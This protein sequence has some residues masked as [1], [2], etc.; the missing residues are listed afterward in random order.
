MK[1][2][3]LKKTVSAFTAVLMTAA[4]CAG[5]AA[6][7]TDEIKVFCDG[8]RMEFDVPAQIINDRVM[9]PMRAVFESFGAKVKWDEETQ[10]ITAK[11]KSKT[12]V[13]TVGSCDMTKNDETYTFDAAP[14]IVDGRTL[15][16]VRAIGDM[17]SL[18][19]EWDETKK[20]VTISSPAD[21]DESYKNNTG[22]IDL[23]D[24][25]VTGNG[26]S[27]NGTVV[28]V[29]EGGDFE[30]VG[31]AE[32]GQITVDTKD[33]VKLRLSG[34]SL[35]NKSGSAIY[36]KDADKAYITL[37]DGTENY[38]S[39]ADEYTSGDSDEKACITSR[40]N[41]EIK[42]GGTLNVTGNYNNGI[43]SSDS[44][45]M[46]NGTI[47]ITA[48]N[49]GIHVNDTFSADGAQINVTAESDGI[50]SEE[51]VDITGGSVNVTTTGDVKAPESEQIGMFRGEER[52][53]RDMTANDAASQAETESGEEVTSKG[54]KADWM[55]DISGGSVTVNSTDHAVSCASDVNIK[56]GSLN[57]SSLNK[58][59]KS[60]GNLTVDDGNIVVTQASEGMESKN[61]MTINGGDIEIHANDDGLNAGGG[62]VMQGGFGF[63]RD[64]NGAPDVNG[65]PDMNGMPNMRGM[66][67]MNGTPDMNG[68]PDMNGTPPM[69]DGFGGH[70]TGEISTE[71]H[72]QINGGV[73]YIDAKNDGIDSNGSI[74]I[75]G[76]SVIVEGSPT[77]GG[78]ESGLDSDGATVINGGEVLSAG[79]SMTTVTGE[80]NTVLI[81]FE[82]TMPAG[83]EFEIKNADASTVFKTT[84]SEQ[85]AAMLYSSDK[86]ETG[87]EYKV[88]ADGEEKY[89]FTVSD[90]LTTVGTARRGM[91]AMH[92]ARRNQN[93]N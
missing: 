24:F 21:D 14:V 53:T 9:A 64:M 44:L 81:N 22:T 61:I 59:I 92:G 75:D 8:E 60:E 43:D 28:T 50:Q 26:V 25:S 90:T 34:M 29:T 58:G 87:G 52:Q 85:F 42:G 84:L 2:N 13:M 40:D 82:E 39:D 5:C 88:Y 71:H 55:L 1:M 51:I 4:C 56:G 37:T 36:I 20:T 10:T 89:S 86:L 18:D 16:P 35:T 78:G 72:I 57:L 91:D 62:S 65:A 48:K 27:V 49:D 77:M 11:K 80:Q 12:I 66:R 38:L 7:E 79:G 19:T 83:T 74:Q 63:A 23:D 54:I 31:T 68:M 76:G 15:V 70:G 46:S 47:N 33:K 45:E 67:D 73:I 3:L 69:R 30:V 32:D 93:M 41:L 6:S 17:L